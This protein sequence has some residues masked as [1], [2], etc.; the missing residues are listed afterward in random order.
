MDSKNL[1]LN[2][3][4]AEK[5][6]DVIKLLKQAGYWDKED[7]WL[8]YGGVENNFSTIGNQQDNPI[9]AL[10]EKIINSIDAVLM[11]E[12]LQRNI[13]P[14]ST[15]APSGFSEALETFFGVHKGNLANVSASKRTDLANEIGLV[16]T[17]SKK[18]PNYIVFDRGEGQEP[19][20]FHDTFL[21]LAKSNKMKIPFVQGKFNMGST[22]VL[23][24][25]GKQNLQ[26]IVSKRC[27]LLNPNDIEWG[28]TI[29][30]RQDPSGQRRNS[31]FQYL[32]PES[33]ILSFGLGEI[34]LL[35]DKGTQEIEPL[36]W[37]TIIKMYDY[38]MSPGYKTMVGF[39]L[40]NKI[41]LLLPRAGLPIRFYERRNYRG[42]SLETTM[43]GLSVRL[44]DDRSDNLEENFPTGAELSIDTQKVKVQIFVF[45]KG[46]DEKYRKNEGVLF[47][48]NGQS[49][50][51]FPTS[52][53]KRNPMKYSYIADSILVIVECDNISGR[54]REDL[55]MNS[56]DRLRDCEIKTEIE[57]QLID[58]LK[59]HQGLKDL[60]LRRRQEAIQDKID[61]SKPLQDI[62]SEVIKNSK[63]LS[64]LLLFGS[65]LSNPFKSQSATQN[66]TY[67]GKQYPTYFRIL[68][69]HEQKN[70]H[71]DHKF[72]IQFETDVVNDYLIRDNYPGRYVLLCEGFPLENESSNLN[73]WNGLATLSVSLP[74]HS[75]SGDQLSFS[76]ELTDDTK[77]EPFVEDFIVN[78]LDDNG[79]H[80]GSLGERKPPVKAG[81]GD[82]TSP[83]GLS[84]P[85]IILIKEDEW[86]KYGFS[87]ESALKVASDGSTGYDFY[88][89]LD[90][91]FLKTELKA[92]QDGQVDLLTAQFKFGLTLF[93]LSL[94]QKR[95]HYEREGRDIEN[96]IAFLSE[97]FAPFIIPMISSLGELSEIE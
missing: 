55:F 90:N 89:N 20:Q 66:E 42:H 85:N 50:G 9:T 53:F 21:S 83:S 39:D 59:N 76:I 1:C 4:S 36:K 57:E 33:T 82:R 34:A 93:G 23:Q 3:L 49:H 11:R 26:L 60:Q 28:F 51:S 52:F 71:L 8:Y 45:K 7:C 14:E 40:Y 5:E 88:V 84:L 22:G 68:K 10:N 17:G 19:Q 64:T 87:K 47:T 13:D 79:L 72:R 24:F 18:R 38:Q 73:L 69:K 65:D 91:I 86:D 78:V 6:D 16:A 62:L 48:I 56:R 95:S 46:S 44:Q 54:A 58:L 30:R 31:V 2:L 80:G 96:D 25:C 61:D 92:H 15:E 97:A 77:M 70:C 37:G 32:A 41:S 12:C 94:L 35:F 63:V 67:L 81:E 74:R 27:S 75:R 29:I 43:A